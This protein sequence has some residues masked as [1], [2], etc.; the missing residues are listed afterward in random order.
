MG[1]FLLA[2]LMVAVDHHAKTLSSAPHKTKLVIAEEA[3]PL[4][5]DGS[6]LYAAVIKPRIEAIQA[7]RVGGRIA[8]RLVDAG[9]RVEKGQV[10]AVLD[11]TDWRLNSEALQGQLAAAVAQRDN[12]KADLA[13]FH[14]L[15]TQKLMS[16]AEL[17][18]Q[19]HAF[20]AAEGQVAALKAQAQEAA[21]K[22]DYTQLRSDADGVIT[23]VMAEPGQVVSEGM[24]VI[25]LARTAEREVEFS[26]PEHRIDDIQLGQNIELSLWSQPEKRLDARVREI[27]PAADPVTRT[28]K[29]RATL[30]KPSSG[31][32]LGM[33]ASVLLDG[34]T[35]SHPAVSLPIGAVFEHD[36]V[37]AVW[38]VDTASGALHLTPVTV[39][40]IAG[41]RCLVTT[42]IK[43]GDLVV[44]AG[45]HRLHADD[46]VAVYKGGEQSARAPDY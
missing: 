31:I 30:L 28:L 11:S 20:A 34:G 24:P 13:R 7:F 8:E 36:G 41:N 16:P 18:R 38:I 4:T 43:P 42:G 1:V 10:L 46:R 32:K 35:S 6:R 19:R 23:K 45:V 15:M 17:D 25:A 29:V 22:L 14:E 26:I 21:K 12:A 44:T 27:A 9:D 40:G 2:A 3:R 33:T 39:G 37:T 5:D